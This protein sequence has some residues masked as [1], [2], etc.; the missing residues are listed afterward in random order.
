[1]GNYDY[2]GV[3]ISTVYYFQFEIAWFS[4]FKHVFSKSTFRVD[5]EVVRG[6]WMTGDK[7]V[8]GNIFCCFVFQQVLIPERLSNRKHAT[9]SF[10]RETKT[11]D[12]KGL[13]HCQRKSEV[14]FSLNVFVVVVVQAKV[15]SL[16]VSSASQSP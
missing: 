16:T 7:I 10:V 11:F 9:H 15:L 5:S 14:A 6:E 4:V 8:A 12:R 13:A 2:E 3:C 1:M